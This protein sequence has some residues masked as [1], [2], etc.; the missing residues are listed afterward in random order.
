MDS[1]AT[2]CAEIADLRKANKGLRDALVRKAKESAG[3]M[4]ALGDPVGQEYNFHHGQHCAFNE[5]L[6]GLDPAAEG[7]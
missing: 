7:S 1:H 3:Y 6:A 4:D 2:L 5:I